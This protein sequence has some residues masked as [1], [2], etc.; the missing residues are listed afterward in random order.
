MGGTKGHHYAVIE[1][2]LTVSLKKSLRGTNSRL[3]ALFQPGPAPQVLE[4]GDRTTGRPVSLPMVGVIGAR[5][6]YGSCS[7]RTWKA[8][9]RPP[10]AATVRP[11]GG[12]SS[13]ESPDLQITLDVPRDGRLLIRRK[14]FMRLSR[15]V[16]SGFSVSLAPAIRRPPGVTIPWGAVPFS[17][18]AGVQLASA[19]FPNR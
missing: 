6:W 11:R 4:A 13:D 1:G 5:S 14:L 7:V 2:G 18:R 8:V 10:I 19:R 17:G 3:D 12:R 15:C 16:V 9:A